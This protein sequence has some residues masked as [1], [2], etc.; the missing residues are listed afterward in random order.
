MGA[1]YDICEIVTAHNPDSDK[2]VA[3]RTRAVFFSRYRLQFVVAYKL[4]KCTA[5]LFVLFG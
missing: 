4:S 2:K 3:R 5:P 1:V